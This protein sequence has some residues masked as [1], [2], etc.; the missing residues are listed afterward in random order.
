MD[1]YEASP[2]EIRAQLEVA[3]SL[4]KARVGFVVI[5]ILSKDAGRVMMMQQARKMEEL[6]A[7]VER[8]DRGTS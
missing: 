3:H 8:E 2:A 5:P 4:A 7:F 6:A 1:I